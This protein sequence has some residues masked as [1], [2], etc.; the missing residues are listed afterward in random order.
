MQMGVEPVHGIEMRKVIE[1]ILAAS[2]DIKS[3]TKQLLE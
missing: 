2:P 3:R 1:E